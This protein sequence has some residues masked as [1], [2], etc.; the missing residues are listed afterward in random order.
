MHIQLFMLKRSKMPTT[1]PFK[2][3]NAKFH[4]S[5]PYHLK[6]LGQMAKIAFSPMDSI[7]DDLKTWNNALGLWLTVPVLQ[8][9]ITNYV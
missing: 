9:N 4:M 1:S 7:H 3:T 2:L 8:I 5:T 6:C